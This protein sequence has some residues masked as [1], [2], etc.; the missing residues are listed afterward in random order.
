MTVNCNSVTV[1]G[2]IVQTISVHVTV[3]VVNGVPVT[4]A[5]EGNGQNVVLAKNAADLY[6]Q[7]QALAEVGQMRRCIDVT[8]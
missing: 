4:I 5:P 2:R 7:Q 3:E 1:Q 6:R 8:A